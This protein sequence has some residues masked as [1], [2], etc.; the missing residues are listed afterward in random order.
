MTL[1][2]TSNSFNANIVTLVQEDAHAQTPQ[3]PCPRTG[4]FLLGRLREKFSRNDLGCI[5]ELIDSERVLQDEE[6][7]V[8]IGSHSG[9]CAIVM[10]GFLVHAA[11]E[12]GS[13][14]ITAIRIPGDLID[15]D[16]FILKRSDHSII[17]AGR[18]RVAIIR[19]ECI[20][21][22]L[23]KDPRAAGA[24][25]CSSLL[26]AAIQRKW[27]EMFG[28]LDASQ[29][30]AHIYC[31]LQARLEF[32]GKASSHAV[33]TPFTQ[34]DLADMSGVSPVHANRAV[35]KL[36]ESGLG[37]IRRGTL[38]PDDWTA[39]ERYAQFDSGYLY[40]QAA[41]NRMSA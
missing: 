30:I 24:M 31:E 40:G 2:T 18:S 17:S 11:E 14:S 37:Q 38:Y 36:R 19:H 15:F 8:E 32:I 12:A 3:E 6:K 22:F 25:W 29:R 28:R 23:N 35:A 39:L 7:F 1:Q 41:L 16:S 34:T 4:N 33:R 9:V 10:D 21:D 5:E 27:I 20:A 13:R 26:D